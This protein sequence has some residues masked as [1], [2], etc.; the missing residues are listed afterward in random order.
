MNEVFEERAEII[1]R[2]IRYRAAKRI[3]AGNLTNPFGD[4]K[5]A[6]KVITRL[7]AEYYQTILD[8]Y[9]EGKRARQRSFEEMMNEQISS[10]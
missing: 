2:G 1:R 5:Y 3:L 4:P 6:T 9:E 7:M 8:D 10:S